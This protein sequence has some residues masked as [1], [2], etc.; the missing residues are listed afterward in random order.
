VHN[1]YFFLRALAEHLG[2]ILPGSIVEA[3]YTQDKNELILVLRKNEEAVV[4]RAHLHPSFCCLYF[5]DAHQRARRNTVDLFTKIHD[6]PIS[7]VR[8]H[9]HERAFSF[10]FGNGAQLTFKMFGNRSNIILFSDGVVDDI[11]RSNLK[12]D[13]ELDLHSLDRDLD[14]SREAFLKVDG[15]PT[16]FMPVLG[17]VLKEYLFSRDY[18][19]C[20]TDEQYDMVMQLYESLQ[21]PSYHIVDWQENLHL[22]LVPIG[23]IRRSFTDPV[24]ALNAFFLSYLREGQLRL[25]K[26]RIINQLTRELNRGLRYIA[27]NERRLQTLR[28]DTN[29]RKIADLIMANLHNLKTGQKEV[30]VADIYNP[31]ENLTIRLKP[32]LSPQKN[33]ELLY[34]KAKKQHIET[35]RLEE[36]IAAKQQD[37]AILE[38]QLNEAKTTES[39]KSLRKIGA[40]PSAGKR[41]DAQL[42]YHQFSFEGFL[43]WLGKSGKSN[44]EMLRRCAKNDL[45]LHAKD[46]AGAHVIIRE[47]AGTNYSS[48]VKEKAAALAA[49]H[50]KRRTDSVCPVIATPR[51]Y[52]RKRK[53]SPPGAVVVDREEEVLLVEPADWQ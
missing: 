30:T 26:T 52:V 41:S 53:G 14:L 27:K 32:E 3:C 50:S 23:D 12:Q 33:A 48:A 38:D 7:A 10:L 13:H 15:N 36:N 22:S 17:K 21:S 6:Q 34:R 37:M 25:E 1:N 49:F 9:L 46:V 28:E 29:Y 5:P 51:K 35:A 20:S 43:V 45:W 24:E 11:F 18:K 40:Q 42:P 31:G 4:I 47:N 16:Q 19:K 8:S 39:L 44:D 2:E